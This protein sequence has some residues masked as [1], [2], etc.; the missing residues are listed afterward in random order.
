MFDFSYI[1]RES[2]RWRQRGRVPA[3]HR[4]VGVF[5]YVPYRLWLVSGYDLYAYGLVRNL[6]PRV[7]YG[8]PYSR[9]TR[10]RRRYLCTRIL[11]DVHAPRRVHCRRVPK[12]ID[13]RV[14]A[15][16]RR[17]K[18]CTGVRIRFNYEFTH[19]AHAYVL[20]MSCRNRTTRNDG[21][22]VYFRS[23]PRGRGPG[24]ETRTE[25]EEIRSSEN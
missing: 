24:D 6:P 13:R 15:P 12:S 23:A 5:A 25:P 4:R 21:R 3:S 20:Y 19:W 7:R 9:A 17:C 1:F 10:R 2:V 16:V 18:T 8:Y 14:R 22:C 11:Y